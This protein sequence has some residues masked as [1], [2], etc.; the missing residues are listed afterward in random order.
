MINSNQKG[1]RI[2]RACRDLFRE[3]GYEARRGQQFSGSP[4]S[5]D[6][7]TSLPIHVEVKGVERLNIWQ[8]AEQAKRD[9]GEGKPWVVC[10]TKNHCGWL[11]TMDAE[12]FFKAVRGDFAEA[13][14]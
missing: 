2:E 10:H 7:I 4:D 1:K 11:I 13:N 6:I 5:P 3:H 12:T 8:A 14:E 9:A